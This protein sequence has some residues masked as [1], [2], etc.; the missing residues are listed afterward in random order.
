MYTSDLQGLFGLLS[1]SEQ[2]G[3]LILQPDTET[4]AWQARFT[5]ARGQPIAC[6]VTASHTTPINM[7]PKQ[8]IAALSKQGGLQWHLERPSPEQA[9]HQEHHLPEVAPIHTLPAHVS[10]RSVVRGTSPWHPTDRPCRMKTVPHLAEWERLHRSIFALV[11]D[12]RTVQEIA[13]ILNKSLEDL[14]PVFQ[15]LYRSG[16]IGKL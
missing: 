15:D 13:R 5:L 7:D 11:D 6:V 14:Q 3:T 12:K 9:Q 10:T 8:A 16:W 4:P 2:S 1:G